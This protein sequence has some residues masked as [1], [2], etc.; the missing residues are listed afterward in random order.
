MYPDGTLISD[1]NIVFR[2]PIEGGPGWVNSERYTIV[3]TARSE[4]SRGMMSGPMLRAL[5]EDR[6]K[7]RIRRESREV[8]VY[9]LTIARGGSKLK[10]FQ[11][12]TC[13][14]FVRPPS[15]SP[16]DPAPPPP[17]GQ[18][19]CRPDPTAASLDPAAQLKAIGSSPNRVIDFEVLTLDRLSEI[20]SGAAGG[21]GRQVIDKTGLTGKFNIRLEYAP[22]PVDPSRPEI[23]AL[24]AAAGEPTAPSL[25]TA[26]QEQ[27]GLKLESAKGVGYRFVIESIE[28]PSDN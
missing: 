22:P 10:P 16:F 7:L 14:S 15:Q 8:D 1:P 26:L 27:L 9:A 21:L 18:R 6:F 2:T 28:R 4:A 17:V 25:E 13:L 19:Y 5:L 20:L 24:R 3:A 11:E 23:A 12:G